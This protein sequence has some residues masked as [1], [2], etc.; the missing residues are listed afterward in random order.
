MLEVAEFRAVFSAQM[1]SAVGDMLAKVAVAVLVFDR[2]RSA[3]AAAAAFAIGYLPW[4]VGGPIMAAIADRMPWKRT[5]IGADL[6]RAVLVGALALPG[7]PLPVVLLLL[8][9][10]ALLSPPFEAARSALLPELLSGDRYVVGVSLSN[11]AGQACQLVGFVLGGPIVVLISPRGALL[12]DAVTFGV[13]ALI[14]RY[15]LANR[16]APTGTAARASLMRE[17]GAGLRL[18]L[19]HPVLRVYVL[20]VWLASAFAYAPE[21]LAPPLA[22][23]LDPSPLSGEFDRDAVAVGLLLGASPLG[24]LI[25]GV[26]IGRYTAPDRRVRALR[27]L[28]LLAVVALV[29]VALGPPL[30]VVLGLF[31]LSGFGM[32]FLLPLNALFVQA[33]PVSFRARAFG[34]VQ[35]GLQVSQGVSI[36]FA[37]LAA[38]HL[39]VTAVVAASGLFGIVLVGALSV[40]WPSSEAVRAPV[41]EPA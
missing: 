40:A 11:I 14:L 23:Y 19:G 24:T 17:T 8:F 15:G 29:P 6:G 22:E 39:P 16:P 30:W 9:A 10:A 12:L 36:I 3:F 18:V 27:P 33:L 4:V 13:S 20:M 37:G 31:V 1:L 7:V 25:G 41:P 21:G 2:T 34:V 26:V 5:L 32:S 35:A 38:E 28:A